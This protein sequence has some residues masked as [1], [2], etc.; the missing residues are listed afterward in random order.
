MFGS[1]NTVVALAV[2]KGLDDIAEVTA[3]YNQSSVNK[4]IGI[5][6]QILWSWKSPLFSPYAKWHSWF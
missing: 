1:V 2:R 6:G 3:H 5:S 4:R